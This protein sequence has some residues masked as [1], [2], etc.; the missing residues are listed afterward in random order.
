MI[1]IK[2]IHPDAAL[3]TR[4]TE[5]SAGLDLRCL[6]EFT[7]PP[8]DRAAIRTGIAVAVPRGTVGMVWP[9]SGLAVKHGIDVLAGV[10][11]ADYRGEILVILVNH[12]HNDV[13][14][15]QYDAIAQLVV[16]E[17]HSDMEMMLVNELDVTGRGDGGFGSTDAA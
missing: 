3:P 17:H 6:R 8:G 14:V 2:R 10:I 9:R 16:Q 11:D 5:D 4:G 15:N 13:V 7:I 12:G 1:R